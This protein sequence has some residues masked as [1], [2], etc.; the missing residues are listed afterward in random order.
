MIKK[1][2]KVLVANR[3]E[4]AV[5]IIRAQRDLGI[6]SV[7]VYSEA[8]KTALHVRLADE[9]YCIGKSQA[10]ESYLNI[11]NILNVA[12][13]AKVDAIHPGYGFLSENHE[14]ARICEER[15]F[16][17]IG[18]S[19]ESIKILGDKIYAR[20]LAK[21]AMIPIVSGTFSEIKTIKEGEIFASQIGY[22]ILLKASGGGGGK[23][24]RIVRNQTELSSLFERARS[25]AKSS[26]G[27]D[28]LYIEKYIENPRHIEVQIVQDKYGNSLH[29]FERECSIQRR[30]QKVIE[31]SPAPSISEESRKKV[32]KMAQEFIKNINYGSAGTV[33]FL[34]DKNENF[35]FLEINTRI[36]VEHPVTEMVTGI[37]LIQ[38]Q[39]RIA[40]GNRLNITQD[41]ITRRGHAIECRI[42]AEDPLNNFVPSGGKIIKYRIGEGPGIR[43]DT[44]VY[45]GVDVTSFYD[46]ILLKIIAHGKDRSESLSRMKRALRESCICGVKTNL[47]LHSAIL[48]DSDFFNGTFDTTY[49]DKN[50]STL[51]NDE[52]DYLDDPCILPA[53]YF[54][55]KKDAVVQKI[56]AK[57]SWKDPRDMMRSSKKIPFFAN[58]LTFRK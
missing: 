39:I 57:S 51:N 13:E 1:F 7:G 18:P 20:K 41:D 15:G 14:F 46:P 8:D 48:N 12:K 34:M 2:K 36:Q 3:G 38:E 55:T 42:Y 47:A 21:T 22:P 35:Y 30:H 49:L 24:M 56:K 43:V 50:I 25:E 37:D 28:S 10:S 33:E 32:C 27:N 29:L 11:E 26:F 23:G 6:I 16:V 53:L 44:G 17:F 52:K 4:I 45:E 5:R 40:A 9:A 31:E 58:K 19:H 54:H